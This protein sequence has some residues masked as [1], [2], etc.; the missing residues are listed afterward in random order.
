MGAVWVW[1][2]RGGITGEIGCHGDGKTWS[3]GSIHSGVQGEDGCMCESRRSGSLVGSFRCISAS[4][5]C[6]AAV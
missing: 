2:L 4:L 3:D 5:G 1:T 6:V